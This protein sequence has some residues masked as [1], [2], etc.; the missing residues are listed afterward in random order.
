MIRCQLG[1]DQSHWKDDLQLL[2][3]ALRST[4]N[5]QTGYTPNML[6]HGREIALPIDVKLGVPEQ[7]LANETPHEYVKHLTEVLPKIH[8]TVRSKLDSAHI[9]QGP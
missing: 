9:R 1:G 4:R 2:A 6:L 7:N 8:E 5:R 3:G